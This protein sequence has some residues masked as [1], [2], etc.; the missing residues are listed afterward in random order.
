MQE[1]QFDYYRGMEA[2]QYTFYR[3]PK[4]LFTAECFKSLSCEAKVLYGLLLDRMSLS[5]KNRWFDEEDRVY[6]IFT[7]EEIAELMNCG[8][9]K[10]VRLLK[11][12]DSDRGIGLI[13]K[14]RLGLG[15]PN[16]IYVK[17][18]IIRQRGDGDREEKQGEKPVNTLNSENHNSRVVKTTNQEFPESQFKNGENHNSGI[19]K[20]TIQEFPESQF[21]NGENHTSGMVEITNQEFPKSQSN[22]TD[23]NKTDLSDTEFSETEYSKTDFNDTESGVLAPIYQN[24]IPSSPSIPGTVPDVMEEMEAYRDLI[25]EHISYECFQDDRFCRREDVDELVELM[26]E[27][28]LLP[29][30]GTVRIAGVEKPVA[31]VKN[32]F[33]K[34]NHEHIEYILTC[35]QSNT[36]KVGNIKAY[37]LTTLYNAPMTI[38]NY[39]TAEV[40]HDLY[41][42]G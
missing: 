7:V 18:F 19:V 35:L 22:D 28:M 31:I 23:I 13:E 36:T 21:K 30:H 42:S 11:E 41:G 40:N 10:A 29:D 4:V 6:I 26:V 15:K 20:T 9:Q 17:N 37:L 39:Y 2:E 27:V 38:S 3:I 8:T 24:L 12:L 16:V 5:I 1:I 14:K 34:L 25:R 32:R 33:M